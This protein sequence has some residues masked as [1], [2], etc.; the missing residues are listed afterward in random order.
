[1]RYLFLI[2]PMLL[3]F[4]VSF[5]IYG[6][7]A[8]LLFLLVSF[9]KK[10]LLSD[11]LIPEKH[12]LKFKFFLV[13]AVIVL[14]VKETYFAYFPGNNFYREEFKNVTEI[15][16]PKG[17]KIIAKASSFPDHFGDYGSAAIFQLD[18]KNIELLSKIMKKQKSNSNDKFGSDPLS[19]VMNKVEKQ[20][21]IHMF[22][23]NSE[24]GGWYKYWGLD[25]LS[26]QCLIHYYSW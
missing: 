11:E 8:W 1:M 6:F 19:K 16:L 4:A 22:V 10:R 18:P 24:D 2:I 20:P 5:V 3:V 9:V 25:T 26:N 15:E 12:F 17:S 13:L 7:F 23:A 14:A 21:T